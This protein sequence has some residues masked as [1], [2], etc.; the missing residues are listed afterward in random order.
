MASEG[1][2]IRE[3]LELRRRIRERINELREELETL[4]SILKLIDSLIKS[5]SITTADRVSRRVST[6]T[7]NA[8]NGEEIGKVNYDED[9][10]VIE[11][12]KPIPSSSS[13]ERVFLKSVLEGLKR[14][15]EELVNAG[16]LD[17]SESLSYDVERD[18]KGMI[19]R[20]VVK[21]YRDQ[22]RLRRIVE[23]LRQSIQVG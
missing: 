7:L 18:D 23:S 15:D 2:N 16:E 9:S 13:V 6:I 11:F 1:I 14:E 19:M 22:R 5:Q 4:E 12:T 10:I 17:S 8:P 3:L 21:N 20:I